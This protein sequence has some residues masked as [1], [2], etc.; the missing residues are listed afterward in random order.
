MR[1][2]SLAIGL[3]VSTLLVSAAPAHAQEDMFFS[4]N[5]AR[6]RY[7]EQ[8]TGEPVILV[9]GNGN[10]VLTWVTRMILPNLAKDYRVI[11]YDARGHGK[12]VSRTIPNNTDV[13]WPLILCGSWI[14]WESDVLTSSAIRWEGEPLG[15]Y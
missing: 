3:L 12:S 8:G 1:G 5:G 7:I 2:V 4:S 14:T 10:T 15:S 9:H 6:L 11:A 13:R